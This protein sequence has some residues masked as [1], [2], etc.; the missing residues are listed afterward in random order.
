MASLFTS[1]ATVKGALRIPLAVTTYDEAL[2]DLIDEVDAHMVG[3]LGLPG[4]T[5]QTYTDRITLTR[6]GGKQVRL[7]AR[8]IKSIVALTNDGGAVSS[9]DYG[10]EDETG[11][12]RMGDL[13]YFGVGAEVVEVTYTAGWDE[14]DAAWKDFQKLARLLVVEDFN[15]DPHAG[16]AART[17]GKSRFE[18]EAG[19]LSD[20]TSRIVKRYARAV[21]WSAVQ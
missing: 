1:L 20:R 13:L 4:L 10:R 11:F 15:L 6:P 7:R 5:V 8:P 21:P 9:S 14:D 3:L 2:G 16:F 18:R 19:E 12:L 17:V